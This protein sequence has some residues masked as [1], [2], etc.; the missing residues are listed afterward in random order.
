MLRTDGGWLLTDNAA[1]LQHAA[2][3]LPA[4]ALAP[5]AFLLDRFS[6][7]HAYLATVL[8]WVPA[9]GLDPAAGRPCA[10]GAKRRSGVRASRVVRALYA[11]EQA[12]HAAA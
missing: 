9:A 12:R 3:R 1:V 4:A 8:N 11:A 7:A 10:P 2:E 6:V 5:E